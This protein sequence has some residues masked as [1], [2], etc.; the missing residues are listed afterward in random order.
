MSEQAKI[1]AEMQ[2]LIM[3]I[4]QNGSTTVEEADRMDELEELLYTQNSF[5]KIT[6][7]KYSLQGE[8]IASLF[9]T[10]EYPAAI[11]KLIECE[12]TPDDFFD[13]IEYYYDDE[14]E[15]EES[16]EMFTSV[17]MES[18]KKDYTQKI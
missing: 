17:F 9:F 5:K 4:I 6:H 12:I 7:A 16:A 11:D 18:L 3:G 2:T 1:I 8:E 10:N 13:F 14:H 15:E